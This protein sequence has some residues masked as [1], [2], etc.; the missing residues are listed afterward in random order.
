[1]YIH[2]SGYFNEEE[3]VEMINE[4]KYFFFQQTKKKKKQFY[5]NI[6]ACTYII[7]NSFKIAD[8]FDNKKLFTEGC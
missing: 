2:I 6:S 5:S 4:M 8:F 7:L 1:M 3:H